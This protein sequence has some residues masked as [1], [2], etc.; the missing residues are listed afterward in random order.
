MRFDEELPTAILGAAVR[1][2]EALGKECTT[3]IKKR[4]FVGRHNLSSS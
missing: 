3:E 2:L 1:V 4:W